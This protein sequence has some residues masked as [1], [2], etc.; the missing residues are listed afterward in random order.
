MV[1][2]G[3]K[4]GLIKLL[5]VDN[6]SLIKTIFAHQ[7]WI[8]QLEFFDNKFLL[9]VGTDGNACLW[10]VNTKD[11]VCIYPMK[12]DVLFMIKNDFTSFHVDRHH[13]LAAAQFDAFILV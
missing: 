8:T 3:D 1:A 6:R 13:L 11:L 9:S 5:N 10:N 2:S 12:G 7:G 4:G